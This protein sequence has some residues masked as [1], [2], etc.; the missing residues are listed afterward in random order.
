MSVVSLTERTPVGSTK[1]PAHVAIDCRNIRFQYGVSPSS[2][3]VISELAMR[4]S[5]GDFVC[6][7]GKS[8]CGKTTLLNIIAGFLRP[9]SGHVIVEGRQV[10]GPDP[11][12]GMVF[13]EYSLFPWLTARGNIEFGLRMSGVP[14]AQRRDTAD[15]YLEL[16]GLSQA[17]NR[18]PFE[19]SG[20]MKQRAAIARA[21]AP[22]PR[23]LLMDEPFAALDALTRGYLQEQLLS[24]YRQTQMTVV[25][26]THNIAEAIALASRIVVLGK[27]G[28]IVEDVPVTAEYP[29]A[30]IGSEF[31]LLYERLASAL[32]ARHA[33]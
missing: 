2:P 21:L 19:L 27:G 32:D 31:N 12:R 28:C 23:A 4:I 7:L 8:G 17:A 26:V 18:Y 1:A 24:I 11:Q 16:V 14:K 25:F 9:T 22:N 10:E 6:I 13:Q 20:G 29:R 15:R 30:R 5:G 33:E 3:P